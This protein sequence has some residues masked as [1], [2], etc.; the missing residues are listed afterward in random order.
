MS[1]GNHALIERIRA[2]I[3]ARGPVPFAWFMQQALY[4]PEHGYY[5][6]GRCAIGRRGDYFTNVSVGPLFGQLLA[7]QF[8]EIWERLGKIENF[9]LVEQG[10]HHGEFARD[11]L[12][13]AR[14]R[15]PDFFSTVNYRIIEPFP[16]LQGRQLQTLA[17]F[18]DKVEWRDSVDALEPF[19]GVHF[20]NELLDAMPVHLIV[21]QCGRGVSAPTECAWLEKFVTLNGDMFVFVDQ[22]IADQTLR[23]HLQKS[24]AQL[25]GYQTEVNLAALDWIDNLSRKLDRGYVLTI[26]YG[27]PR[28]EFFAPHRSAGTLQVRAQHRLLQSPFD[29]IGHAD[30]TAHVEW[31][32]IVERAEACGF[33]VKG[34]TDQ[35]HFITGI[36]SE[37]AHDIAQ[38]D[39]DAKANRALQTLLHPEMLGRNF[40]ILAL[41]KNVDLVAPLA[42]LKFAREPRSLL[43]LKR[44][45]S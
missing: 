40:Q 41:G 11:V 37:L 45:A 21:S 3:K 7:A 20:S 5:S 19:I 33:E 42:G 17:G 16:V 30:I 10:A 14:K 44:V 35:H 31:T 24:P 1:T 18:E 23:D 6:S 32:S 4:H 22:P 39:A 13:S 2:E 15:W 8:A 34:F 43:G 12:E 36:I 28:D 29:E 25:A 9:V 27:H 38:G 26:D